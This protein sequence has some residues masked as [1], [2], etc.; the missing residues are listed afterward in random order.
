MLE[1]YTNRSITPAVSRLQQLK[2]QQPVRGH[3]GMALP[4]LSQICSG[5]LPILYKMDRKPD[6]NVFLN[7]ADVLV[8]P[9]SGTR[10]SLVE[11]RTSLDGL[12]TQPGYVVCLNKANKVVLLTME[13][14]SCQSVDLKRNDVTN[15][16]AT[17]FQKA[18]SPDLRSIAN[19]VD[20]KALNLQIR[21]SCDSSR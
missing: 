8:Q 19:S 20:F 6:W 11:K 4:W 3:V 13:R 9:T 2:Q 21:K 17:S 5:L 16:Y 15:G 12:M 14:Q 18:V 1:M 7:I 10:P